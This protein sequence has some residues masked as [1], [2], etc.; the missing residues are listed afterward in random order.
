MRNSPICTHT[1][2]TSVVV[3]AQDNKHVALFPLDMERRLVAL[4]MLPHHRRRR[5]N[6]RDSHVHIKVISLFFC[7]SSFFD[8]YIYI[9]RYKWREQLDWTFGLS[10]V[11]QWSP[12][13]EITTSATVTLMAKSACVNEGLLLESQEM[14]AW[15]RMLEGVKGAHFS[16]DKF[17]AIYQSWLLPLK[18]KAPSHMACVSITLLIW[19]REILNSILISEVSCDSIFIYYSSPSLPPSTMVHFFNQREKK[20]TISKITII[21]MLTRKGDKDGQKIWVLFKWR[22]THL[23]L[24]A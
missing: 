20:K 22:V 2:T 10:T 23:S 9:Y 5:L 14:W 17:G 6:I 16:P 15:G 4:E 11:W 3:N 19:Y 1:H 24:C 21:R 13:P 8:I 7:M 12:S 18:T